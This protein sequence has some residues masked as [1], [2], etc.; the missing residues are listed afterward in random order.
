LI[1]QST[2]AL[3]YVWNFGDGASSTEENPSHLYN[4]GDPKLITLIAINNI[5]SDTVEL[6]FAPQTISSLLANVPNVFSPNNDGVN[7]CYDLGNKIDFSDCSD[8]SVF[9]RWGQKVFQS[10]S[11]VN[12]WNGKQNTSGDDLPTGVYYYIL[13]VNGGQYKGTISLFR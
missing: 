7:D 9:N 5:C 13:N 2:D 12:C 1:N 8:W 4:F 10:T 3:N 11:T 6:D